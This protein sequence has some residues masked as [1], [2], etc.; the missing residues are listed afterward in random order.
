M[1]VFAFVVRIE[2]AGRGV[3]NKVKRGS[4]KCRTMTI[5]KKI[6]HSMAISNKVA[7]ISSKAAFPNRRDPSKNRIE[8]DPKPIRFH[9]T[10]S[11]PH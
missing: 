3:V 1:P 9:N 7:G 5:E 2:I 11:R 10:I 4:S 6:V 8:I